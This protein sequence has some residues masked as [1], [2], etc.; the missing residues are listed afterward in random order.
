MFSMFTGG[1]AAPSGV[2]QP[3]TAANAN[4]SRGA[5]AE[6]FVEALRSQPDPATVTAKTKPKLSFAALMANDEPESFEDSD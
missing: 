1:T 4:A 3:S 6:T 5:A 2:S